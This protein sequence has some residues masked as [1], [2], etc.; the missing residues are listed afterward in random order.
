MHRASTI[1]PQ[2][3]KSIFIHPKRKIGKPISN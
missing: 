2:I 1:V 3:I